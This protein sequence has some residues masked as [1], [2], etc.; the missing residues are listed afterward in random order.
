M[1]MVRGHCM[2]IWKG[3]MVWEHEN[4][5]RYGNM[6]REHGKGIWKGTC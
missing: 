5:R 2:G 1:N 3:N 6:E 4:G